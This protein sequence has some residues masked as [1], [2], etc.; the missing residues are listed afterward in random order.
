MID[1]KELEKAEKTLTKI[2]DT[3]N[4]KFGQT[5]SFAIFLRAEIAFKQN[6]FNKAVLL[7]DEFLLATKSIDYTGLAHLKIGLCY[8]MLQN[9]L[10]AK[11][12]FI[13]ARNGNL[14]IPEDL[15]AKNESYIFYN[16]K[17]TKNDKSLI[18]AENYFESG[19]YRKA[20][21]TIS[22]IDLSE[23]ENDSAIKLKII[24]AKSY[25]CLEKLFKVKETVIYFQNDKSLSSSSYL[26][27]YFLLLAQIKYTERDFIL[28]QEHLNSAFENCDKSD[29]KLMR[30]LVNLKSKLRSKK[31]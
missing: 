17:F 10:L 28:S 11:K 7:Y 31:S 27:E 24:E 19:K 5:N 21:D 23:L 9:N 22:K 13:L 25:L 18:L 12:Y 30:Q 26:A 4:E 15:K 8:E 1:M 14:D 20:I 16:K 3:D 2:I 6:D 29:N